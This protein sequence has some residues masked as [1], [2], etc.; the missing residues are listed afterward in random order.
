MPTFKIVSN[1]DGAVMASNDPVVRNLEAE[2]SDV[3]D[4]S[5]A[6][7]PVQDIETVDLT[8]DA[9]TVEPDMVDL[10]N[11]SDD[12]EFGMEDESFVTMVNSIPEEVISPNRNRNPNPGFVNPYARPGT[13]HRVL[14]TQGSFVR[15]LN[16]NPD[17][18]VRITNFPNITTT[19]TTPPRPVNVASLNPPTSPTTNITNITNTTPSNTVDPRNPPYD[20]CAGMIRD[21]YQ[22]SPTRNQHVFDL[23]VR[24]ESACKAARDTFRNNDRIEE[25]AVRLVTNND[26]RPSTILLAVGA[27]THHAVRTHPNTFQHRFG[28]AINRGQRKRFDRAVFATYRTQLLNNSGIDTRGLNP[29]QMGSAWDEFISDHMFAYH[30]RELQTLSRRTPP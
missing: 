5:K 10:T 18:N 25:A 3:A 17:N 4:D 6:N 16:R 1:E 24:Q 23:R 26:I 12:D 20:P 21:P 15:D 30:V 29:D 2:L 8:D 14:T 11:L 13:L 22:H 28:P 19:P 27:A 7:P 9:D